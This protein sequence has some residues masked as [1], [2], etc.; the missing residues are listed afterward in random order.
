[1]TRLM[2]Q[3]IEPDEDVTM[4]HTMRKNKKPE[5]RLNGR[6]WIL[7]IIMLFFGMALTATASWGLIGALYDTMTAYAEY[8][9]LRVLNAENKQLWTLNAE[10]K[11]LRMMN[12]ENEQLK[13]MNAENKQLWVLNAENKQLRMMNT[14]STLVHE[15]FSCYDG[16]GCGLLKLLTLNSHI[17][18]SCDYGH[19]YGLLKLLTLNSHIP[20]SCDDGQECRL[21]KQLTLD[22]HIPDIGR[23]EQTEINQDYIGW[24][25]IKGTRVDYPVVR[26]IDNEEYLRTTFSKKTNA[27]GAIFMDYRCTQGFDEPLCIIYG[28][29]MND[30]SMFGPL[31][32][33][34]DKE[35]LETH[36]EIVIITSEGETLNYQIFDVKSTDAWDEVYDIASHDSS[37]LIDKETGKG[38]RQHEA[39]DDNMCHILVLS[40]CLKGSDRDGRLLIFATLINIEGRY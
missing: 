37:C 33:Y 10:N 30:G 14:V 40:T 28:H 39:S 17:P 32:G 27:A 36:Q 31:T 8:E 16:H 7:F 35:F 5:Y 1:M 12:A 6:E 15:S 11:Q 21:F 9:H 19:G 34:L 3:I 23:T 22:S 26:G 25:T 2:Q 18:D 24:I 29:R 20:D 13:M 4:Y 38:S